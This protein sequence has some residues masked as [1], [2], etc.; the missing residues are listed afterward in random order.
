M[1]LVWKKNH[2]RTS[3]FYDTVFFRVLNITNIISR[4][5]FEYGTAIYNNFQT[6]GIHT[7][8]S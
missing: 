6:V 7:N 2:M 8:E 5:N 3:V 4:L 1:N